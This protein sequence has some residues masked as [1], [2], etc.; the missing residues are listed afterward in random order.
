MDN[1]EPLIDL[2]VIVEYLDSLHSGAK[3]VPP[4]G[5]ARWKAL[6]LQALAD[7]IL[8]AAVLR[9]GSRAGR[10]T[11]SRRPSSTSSAR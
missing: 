10:R 6:R 3:V 4:S 8:D 5:E 7:G 1:G 9:L 2:P 11:S